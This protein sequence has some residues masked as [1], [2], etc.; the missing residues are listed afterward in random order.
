MQLIQAATY[1]VKYRGMPSMRPL[2]V[3]R[4]TPCQALFT[5]TQLLYSMCVEDQVYL[6]FDEESYE[7]Y[8]KVIAKGCSP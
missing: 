1:E 7:F 6:T 4:T 2:K 3:A 8:W 5:N